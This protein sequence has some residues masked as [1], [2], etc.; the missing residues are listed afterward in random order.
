MESVTTPVETKTPVA[1]RDLTDSLPIPQT[2]WP[3]VHQFA[4]E[5]PNPTSTP[6]TIASA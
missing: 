5:V 3:L 1:T 6:E 2:A 4:S